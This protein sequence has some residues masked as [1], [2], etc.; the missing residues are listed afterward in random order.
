MWRNLLRY[1]RIPN[2]LVFSTIEPIMFVLLFNFVFGGVIKLVVHGS[3]IDYL[4]PGIFVQATIFG[5][6]HTGVAIAEDLNR[7][8]VDRFRSLPMARIA[9][10]TGRVAADL[11]RNIFVVI[12]MTGV[13]FAIGFRLSHGFL[14]YL[15]V[16]LLTVGFGVAFSWISAVIGLIAKDVETAQA[17]GFIWVI[18]L[19]FASSAFVPIPTM[20]GWLQA[21]SKADPV[22]VVV[23]T[24]RELLI[25]GPLERNLIFS[26]CWIAGIMIVCIPM[27]LKLYKNLT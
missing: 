27:T 21:F 25:G 8:M 5:A 7:G 15:G 2:L 20:P 17:A 12:L 3:Y 11:I 9:V 23:E 16:L 24:M 4:L 18:P 1:I 22:S 10:L 19:T 13:G 26:L 14:P 6:T